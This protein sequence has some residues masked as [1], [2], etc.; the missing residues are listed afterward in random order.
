MA[1]YARTKSGKY[2]VRW[3]TLTGE[4]RSKTVP[5]KNVAVQLVAKVEGAHALGHDWQPAIARQVP[6]LRLL[7]E[8]YL[9]A[10]RH[11][12]KPET[13][14]RYAD[15]IETFVAWVETHDRRARA[16]LLSRKLLRDF[17][18]HVST[19]PSR[20]KRPRAAST[21]H[22]ILAIVYTAWAWSYEHDD[23]LSDG[24]WEGSIPRPRR[25][26]LPRKPRGL[27]VRAP[28]WQE[29]DRLIVE[30]DGWAQ[31]LAVLQRCT[32]MRR[33]AAL[34]VRWAHVDL[35]HGWMHLP[36]EVT[37][38]S[39][40]GR[41]V[42]LAPTLVD[43][44][45]RWERSEGCVIHTA[46]TGNL[47]EKRLRR[48]FHRGWAASGVDQNIWKKR[49]THSLRKGFVSGLRAAGADSDAVEVLVGH[50]L[51]IK[52]AYIDQAALGLRDVVALVPPL[53]KL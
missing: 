52:A 17:F 39:Y 18:D 16:D 44:L 51:G 29:M 8:A 20:H 40:G 9:R 21:C 53:P 37:K 41:S 45:A 33:G 10:R 15:T 23:E 6:R 46:P 22:K 1:S 49:P 27:P 12:L 35:E 24:A 38:G 5:S 48:D 13:L 50:S 36:D 34:A 47:L 3:R 4:E 14:L 19:T 25:P 43:E 42:P 28:T 32:G 31:Q 30:L 7:M 11:S 26:E 2:K